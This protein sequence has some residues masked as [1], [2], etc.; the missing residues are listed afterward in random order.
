MRF[1]YYHILFLEVIPISVFILSILIFRNRSRLL[2]KNFN[3]ELLE[4]YI[5]VDLRKQN[6]YKALFIS[7]ALFFLIISIARPQIGSRKTIIN[8]PLKNIYFAV[9]LSSSMKAKDISPSRLERAKIDILSVINTLQSENVGLIFFADNAFLQCPAT[10]DYDIITN[11]VQSISD[12]TTV[13]KKTNIISPILLTKSLLKNNGYSSILIVLTDGEDNY[14]EFNKRLKYLNGISFK[15]L[16]IL[17]GTPY[18]TPIP[19]KTDN[20]NIHY[21]KNSYGNLILTKINTAKIKQIISKIGG[22]YIISK[23]PLYDTKYAKNSF[24]NLRSKVKKKEF[25]VKRELYQLFL[26]LAIICIILYLS[27][28]YKN[29]EVFGAVKE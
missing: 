27:I 6:L 13:N 28:I 4:R 23:N 21:L 22:G 8:Q 1:E 18:G 16:F 15:L 2:E 7:L 9:D 17:I 11:I 24:K 29:K 3:I 12:E 20:G 26:V 19:D 14:E 25:T 10:T 5:E